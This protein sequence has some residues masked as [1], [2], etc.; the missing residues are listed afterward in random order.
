NAGSGAMPADVAK[1][2]AANTW[3]QGQTAPNWISSVTP[4]ADIRAFGAK[5]DGATDD[6]AALQA[7]ITGLGTAG[8]KILIPGLGANGCYIANP[9]GIAWSNG[10]NNL[11]IEVMGKL[12]VGSTIVSPSFV[13]W[14][15][16]SGAGG[17]QFAAT[18]SVGKIQ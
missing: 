14:I 12:R 8:G 16:K 15:G 5:C 18:G 17:P 13:N 1:V 3:T 11:D 2:D 4:S 10:S 7:A 6:T 9:T